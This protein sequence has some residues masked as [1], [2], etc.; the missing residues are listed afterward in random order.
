VPNT[1]DD[2]LLIS[3][4]AEACRAPIGTVR[5]WIRTGRLAS[6]RLGRRRMIRREALIRF[7]EEAGDDRRLTITRQS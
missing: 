6:F 4:V 2:L 7:L 5:H 3:E 1:T